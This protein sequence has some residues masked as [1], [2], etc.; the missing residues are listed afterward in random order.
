[1]CSKLPSG[2]L[3]LDVAWSLISLLSAPQEKSCSQLLLTHLCS[4]PEHYFFIC[5]FLASRGPVF[6]GGESGGAQGTLAD[7]GVLLEM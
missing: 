4:Q 5:S 2:N 3:Y 7:R 6:G 1:M